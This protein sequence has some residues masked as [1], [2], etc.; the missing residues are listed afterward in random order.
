LKE[1]F[2]CAEGS[3]I[4]RTHWLKQ[5][6]W[7][8]RIILLYLI[9]ISH[10][11]LSLNCVWFWIRFGSA[12]CSIQNYQFFLTWLNFVRGK[13][14]RISTVLVVTCV[15]CSQGQESLRISPICMCMFSW[16]VSIAVF[17]WI[18]VKF[19]LANDICILLKYLTSFGSRRK[20][21]TW[22]VL[23]YNYENEE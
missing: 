9:S 5:C 4:W 22:L 2:L 19:I 3:I 6:F 21:E 1:I 18:G 14:S 16:F 12:F 13:S 11:Y 10:L 7:F 8:K 15:L 23:I 20:V 17:R